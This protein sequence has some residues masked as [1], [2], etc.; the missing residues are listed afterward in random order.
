MRLSGKYRT[1]ISLVVLGISVLVWVLLL[2]NPGHILGMQHCHVSDSGP[3]K[4]SFQMLLKMNPVSSLLLGWGLMVVAMMLPALILPIQYVYSRTLKRR[5]FW[6]A[7]LFVFGY[8]AAWMIAGIFMTAAILGLHVLMPNS[9][10]PAIAVGVTALIWQFSP[11]KQQCLN[12]GHDHWVLAAFGWAANRDA[13]MFGITHGAWCVGSGWALM[14]FPMLLPGGH[15]FAM[16]VVTFI[17]VS[18]HFEHPQMPRWRINFR[19]KLF[20]IIAAQTQIKIKQIPI[21]TG[22]Y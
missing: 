21:V 19:G 16:I 7:L 6:S 10:L 4:A 17:M 2:V 18:E 15:N 22:K 12:G 5:R 3:S 11:A 14:L 1:A 8:I 20:R 13:L 9:Y